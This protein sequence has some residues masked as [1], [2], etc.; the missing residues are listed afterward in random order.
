[1]SLCIHPSIHPSLQAV[2]VSLSQSVSS[3]FVLVKL[4]RRL[5]CDDK[6]TCPCRPLGRYERRRERVAGFEERPVARVVAALGRNAFE[7]AAETLWGPQE[8]EV[9]LEVMGGGHYTGAGV[10]M[11]LC[12]TGTAAAAGG[13][14]EVGGGGWGGRVHRR[15]AI[16]V[17]ETRGAASWRVRAAAWAGEAAS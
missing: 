16:G 4:R 8:V 6:A 9:A 14:G 10:R 5:L 15:F 2:S 17:R 1:M 12:T 7:K 11:V 3:T 13:G